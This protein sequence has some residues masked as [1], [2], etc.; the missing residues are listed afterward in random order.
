MKYSS[1]QWIVALLGARMHYAIPRILQ[2]AGLLEHLYTDICAAKGL[3]KLLQIVPQSLQ[4]TRLKRLL[5]RIPQ[6]IPIESITAFNRFGF[7]YAQKLRQ[8]QSPSETIDAFLWAGKTFCQLILQQGWGNASGIYTFNT[9]G[10]ELLQ[11]ARQ[12]G[13]VTI[14]EQTI[15]P[16]AMEYKLLQEEY[17]TFPDWEPP[18]EE[19]SSL[20]E[21]SARE[22]AEWS[23]ADVI[24]CGSEFVR[25]GIIS[26]GGSAER[27]QVLPYGVDI[28]FSLP[29]RL[30]HAGPLRVLTV[31]GVGLRKGSP[32]ILAVAK[33]LQ[34]LARF[35]LVGPLGIRP[36]IES[37]LSAHVELVGGVPRSQIV[38]HYAW[39]DIF[40]LPSICEGSATVI[41]EALAAG[42]P[43]ICTPNA[44][45]VVQ[46]GIDGFIVPIRNHEA[47]VEK[48]ELLALQPELRREM[49]QNALNRASKYT[50]DNYGQSLVK[51]LG[52]IQPFEGK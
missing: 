39:A 18:L 23:K 21:L 48:L 12:Q 36:E 17:Q 5:G 51:I 6:G 40:L 11:N 16:K 52:E 9:A 34:G 26:C 15:A 42:L 1:N 22:Q 33:Q 44:G 24:L 37:L 10:L 31:G 30:S 7:E 47:I 19:D 4:P 20:I 2:Q 25:Q 43:V 35:R 3:P 29:E 46:D 41:Y 27:C 14:M 32:H 45:S 13:L 28:R 8:A 38:D 50:L 49:S